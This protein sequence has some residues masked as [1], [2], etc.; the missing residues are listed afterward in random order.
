MKSNDKEKTVL[1][2]LNRLGGR[3]F[4]K[5]IAKAAGMSPQ[6]ASKYLLS[7]EGK[8]AIIRDDSQRPHIFWEISK[9]VDV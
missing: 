3:A 5:R 1:E 6:T 8:G 7:L 2:A 9:G 4:S